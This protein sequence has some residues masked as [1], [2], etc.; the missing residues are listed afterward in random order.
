MPNRKF[1]VELGCSDGRCREPAMRW[2]QEHFGVKFVDRVCLPGLLAD[3]AN[4]KEPVSSIVRASL[5]TLVAAHYVQD[6]V[7]FAHSG[8]A[9]NP[10]A[11]F[12]QIRQLQLAARIVAS[13]NIARSVCGVFYSPSGLTDDVWQPKVV[14]TASAP[15]AFP[16]ASRVSTHGG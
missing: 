13:W 6:A 12:V 16:V 11:D 15:M 10:V 3:I 2:A 9:G 4:E 14:V 1:A 7:V 8:C 5:A